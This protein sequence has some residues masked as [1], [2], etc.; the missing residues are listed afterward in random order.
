MQRLRA[1]FDPLPYSALI[2]TLE[3][4]FEHLVQLRQSSLYFQP[5]LLTPDPSLISTLT[6]SRRDAV[7]VILMNLYILAC[8]LRRGT[9]VP[10][11]LPGPAAARKK[12]LDRFEVLEAEYEARNRALTLELAKMESSQSVAEVDED[13]K[14]DPRRRW[15]DVYHYAFSSA[16]TDVVESVQELQRWSRRVVGE[17]R[18]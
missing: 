14:V 1:P 8:A 2:S 12:L 18:W 11:Y 3:T 6:S 5:N 9:P 17:E 13:A 4:L 15:E 16:L 7:A 10:R